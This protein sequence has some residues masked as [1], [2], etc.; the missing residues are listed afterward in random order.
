[1]R[2]G[3]YQCC[4]GRIRVRSG[5]MFYHDTAYYTSW[6]A[7]VSDGAPYASTSPHIHNIVYHMAH[8]FSTS[9]SCA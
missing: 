8:V 1:M 2:L 6:L 7:L 4:Y 3:C 5:S 9:I